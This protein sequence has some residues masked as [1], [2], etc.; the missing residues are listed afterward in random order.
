MFIAPGTLVAI[1]EPLP[2]DKTTYRKGAQGTFKLREQHCGPGPVQHTIQILYTPGHYEYLEPISEAD[3]RTS[4]RPKSRR[5]TQRDAARAA[6]ADPKPTS[7][8][9]CF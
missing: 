9:V 8:H 3:T 1:Y 2:G 6:R 7:S 4:S 5:A